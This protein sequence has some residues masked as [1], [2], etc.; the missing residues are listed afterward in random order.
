MTQRNLQSIFDLE[1][2]CSQSDSDVYSTPTITQSDIDFIVDDDASLEY[3]SDVMTSDCSASGEQTAMT[4]E[5]RNHHYVPN[6]LAAWFYLHQH[7]S[8]H[9]IFLDADDHDP[10]TLDDLILIRVSFD[11]DNHTLE[12]NQ[13]IVRYLAP[14]GTWETDDP[15]NS[16]APVFTF[17]LRNTPFSIK[18]E[19]LHLIAYMGGTIIWFQARAMTYQRDSRSLGSNSLVPMILPEGITNDDL[20]EIAQTYDQLGGNNSPDSIYRELTPEPEVIDL[21]QPEV[22]DLTE[23]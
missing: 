2:Q 6:P 16:I 22:I 1:A 10:P 23:D 7:P 20:A 3:D 21:T 12:F 17:N 4:Q 13:W 14:S 15:A 18:R 5:L 8:Y 9:R 19:A 11:F